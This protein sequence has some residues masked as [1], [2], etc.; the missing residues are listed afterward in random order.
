MKKEINTNKIM[1]S[2]KVFVFVSFLL[3]IFI[4][5]ICYLCM[6]DYPVNDTTISAFIENRNIKEEIIE[7]IRGSIY[8]VNGNILAQEVA[9]YTVIAYLDESRSE[10]SKTINHVEDV[11]TTAATLA[12][13]INM[14]VDTLVGLLSKDAYQ[15]ELGPGGRN[16]SQIQMEAIRDLNLPGI[17]F[18]KTS[19]RYY[20]NGD[21]ASYIVGYTVNKEDDNGKKYTKGE[22]GIEEY[23]NDELTGNEG[24]ITYEKDRYGYK[25]A[26]G[27]EYIEDAED[28]ND[29]YLTIDNNI[30]LFI[31]NAIE[32]AQEKSEA[33]WIVTAVADAKTGAILGYSS[34]PSFDPNL[35]NLVSYLDPVI[36]NS[37]EPGSTMK[38]FSYMC[39]I[40]S[41]NYVGSDTYESGSKT[42][43]SEIDGDEV[44]IN[45][46]NKKGWGT[47]S[48]DQG[49][50]LSSNIAVANLLETT[51]SKNDLKACYEDYGFGKRTNFYQYKKNKETYKKEYTGNITFK[52]DIEAATAGYGQGI[53]TTPIQ[54][55]QALSIL[56]NN[57]DMLKPYIIDKI[58]DS[59]TGFN[60]Y[61]SKVEKTKDVVSK[62]STDKMI[63][64]LRSV[65]QPDNTT[66]TGYAYYMDGYDL[67]GKTGTAQIF[68]YTKGAYMSGEADYIYSF[69]GLYPGEDPNLIIYTAI[70]RP[71]DATNYLADMVKE[72]V[73]N[74]SKYLNI[75]EEQPEE[76]SYLIDSYINKDTSFVVNNLNLN[77][78]KVM[79]IGNGNKIINQYPSK[80]TRILNDELVI[81]LTNDYSKTMPNLVGMSFKEV[82]TILDFLNISYEYEGYGYL[83]SQSI[84]EDTIISDEVVNL[85]FSPKY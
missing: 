37:Y 33:E 39:A 69:S 4:G 13:Y 30:Q 83:E 22:L 23:F 12:P 49:F 82:I 8:D 54:H 56:A 73:I 19:K 50:A 2:K 77:K 16:L 5:R 7:P 67:V 80:G 41:G 65:V 46:W 62:D 68:D 25:I 34:T 40:E 20:P 18:I 28:G 58:V 38:I 70:K 64:L 60:I 47:I 72:I 24:Y 79:T 42:Y 43:E 75:E 11:N 15:V 3:L 59:N 35:R 31:E 32:K 81:L 85:V 36:S 48:Y 66:A 1:V 84:L 9:S 44:T 14:D 53:T 78:F 57:G 74:T 55:I 51:I 76:T 61:N 6:V 52:Y 45:D 71:K 21:F 29:I 27:R 63:E 10:N 17:D 26:N